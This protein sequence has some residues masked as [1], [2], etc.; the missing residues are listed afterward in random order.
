MPRVFAR[1]T[2]TIR[3]GRSYGL[4]RA[5]YRAVRGA[6]ESLS[7]GKRINLRIADVFAA[8]VSELKCYPRIPRAFSV[9]PAEETD[10]PALQAFFSKPQKVRDRMRR[11]DLCVILL[12]D[13]E[14]CAAEWVSPGPKAYQEDWD[15]LRCV[16][17]IPAHA[18]WLYDGKGNERGTG[19]WAILMGRLTLCLNDLGIQDVFL[20][21]DYGNV[22]SMRSHTSLGY[23]PVGR[24]FHL[25]IAGLSLRLYRTRERGWRFL[26]GRIGNLELSGAPA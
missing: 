11:G 21:S 14:I 19:T 26:P 25:A 16:F 18:C 7:L 4:S 22:V 24:I 6:I 17:R 10:V 20:Q 3:F 13:G 5:A 8:S 12:A 15:Q 9:R 23:R 2:R 1:L